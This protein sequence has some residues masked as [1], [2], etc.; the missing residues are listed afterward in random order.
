MFLSNPGFPLFFILEKFSLQAVLDAGVGN[1]AAGSNI[2]EISNCYPAEAL[3][4]AAPAAHAG[5]QL[6]IKEK[7]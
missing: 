6:R 4:P 5:N 2:F 1:P 7:T 3:N